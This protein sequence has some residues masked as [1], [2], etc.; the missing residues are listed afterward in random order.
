MASDYEGS[1][2]YSDQRLGWPLH[3]DLGV[4]SEAL[5]EDQL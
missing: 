2:G 4:V 1:E 3:D 5:L